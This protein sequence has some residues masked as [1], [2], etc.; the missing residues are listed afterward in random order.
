MIVKMVAL[1]FSLK[2]LYLFQKNNFRK[3]E[4]DTFPLFEILITLENIQK[5]LKLTLDFVQ[6]HATFALENDQN[7]NYD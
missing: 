1:I 5:Y 7:D 3:P 2:K 4:N 6:N